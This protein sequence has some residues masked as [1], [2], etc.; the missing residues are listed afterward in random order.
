MEAWSTR[1]P[2]D[3]DATF[4]RRRDPWTE[5]LRQARHI[6]FADDAARVATEAT[7]DQLV[8]RALCLSETLR[9]AAAQLGLSQNDGKLQILF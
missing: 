2:D 4:L 8:C 7:P 6:Q 5:E 9:E 1:P 3:S